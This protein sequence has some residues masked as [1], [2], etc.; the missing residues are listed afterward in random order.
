MRLV[1]LTLLLIVFANSQN[2]DS[3]ES[4][5]A[6]YF[7][8]PVIASI[9]TQNLAQNTATTN[10]NTNSIGTSG[11]SGN[12]DFNQNLGLTDSTSSSNNGLPANNQE[13]ASERVSAA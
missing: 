8:K 11:G 6:L 5:Q 4:L 10:S 2:S 13:T 12:S 1:L 7:P 9:N 3:A